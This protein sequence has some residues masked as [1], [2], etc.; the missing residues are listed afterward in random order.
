MK[1]YEL[2]FH[3]VGDLLGQNRHFSAFSDERNGK[4][5]VEDEATNALNIIAEIFNKSSNLSL[6]KPAYL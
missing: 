6:N 1:Q 2:D 3:S 5:A 4:T